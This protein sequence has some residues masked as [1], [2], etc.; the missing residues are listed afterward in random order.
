M[1]WV[2]WIAAALGL[3]NVALVVLRSVWNYP[4]GIVMVSLYGFVFLDARLYSDALLQLFFLVIQ[5]YGWNA[6]LRSR[7]DAGGRVPVRWMT[8]MARATWL[9]GTVAASLVWGWGMATYTDAAAPYVDGAVA[10]ASVAAQILLSLRRVENWVLWIAV[11]MVAIGL[12]YSRGL[13]ATAI[14]YAVFLVMACVGFW[15]WTRAARPG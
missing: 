9:A 8:P 4:F 14:L 12:F 15:Q 3:V 5:V 1:Q 6:W 7:G 10:I 13:E 2:E 11:D